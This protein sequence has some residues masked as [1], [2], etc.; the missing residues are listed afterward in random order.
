MANDNDIEHR[1]STLVP[2]LEWRPDITR[3]LILLRAKRETKQKRRLRLFWTTIGALTITVVVVAVPTSRV[4]A[5]RYLSAC[6][7]LLGRM[8]GDASNLAYNAAERRVP[9]P[10]VTAK[11]ID[12]SP[13]MLS[14]LR[15]KTILLNFW[16]PDCE[17][18]ERE[19]H[20]FTEFQQLYGQRDFIFLN[21]Q[22]VAGDDVLSSLGRP[23]TIPTT[24]LIDKSG[25]IAVTHVGRCT[26][27][28]YQTAIE[29]LL[30]EP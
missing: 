29:T 24:L 23:S 20:W 2:E 10:N 15:G 26:K 28:E 21:R 12:G 4:L 8:S 7:S 18:C 14:E 22:V 9:A 25:R 16:K 19:T 27:H 11:T 17:T 6:V 1:L 30:N 3:G 13:V 5:A